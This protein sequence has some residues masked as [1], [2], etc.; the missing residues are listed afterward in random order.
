MSPGF[1]ES[2]PSVVVTSAALPAKGSPDRLAF[3]WRIAA[4]ALYA[5]G[6]LFFFVRIVV[7]W[8][9]GRRLGPAPSAS[10]R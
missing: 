10:L 5:A 3:D 8:L 2:Q 9:L 1:T 7:G 4:M 6:A